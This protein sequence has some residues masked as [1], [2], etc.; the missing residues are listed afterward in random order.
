M[1]SEFDIAIGDVEVAQLYSIIV[2]LEP[3]V[4]CGLTKRLIVAAK[5]NANNSFYVENSSFGD[6]GEQQQQVSA[7]RLASDSEIGF[8][9][10]IPSFTCVP[11]RSCVGRCT[12]RVVVVNHLV[13]NR[14]KAM[15]HNFFV[16]QGG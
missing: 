14:R 15:F 13:S 7:L 6:L 1:L 5:N 10:N 11:D 2:P 4:S 12:S 16:V 9:R 8:N 3:M